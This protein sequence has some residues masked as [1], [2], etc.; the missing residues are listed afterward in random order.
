MINK[1]IFWFN[2]RMTKKK[3]SY[4]RGDLY[5]TVAEPD[6]FFELA[7]RYNISIFSIQCLQGYS[8]LDNGK[9]IR[10]LVLS[11]KDHRAML[12]SGIEEL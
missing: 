3:F 6:N 2:D 8:Q 12:D 7:D 4:R 11:F 5:F 10:G 1:L 9:W